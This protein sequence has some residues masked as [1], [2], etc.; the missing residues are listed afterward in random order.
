MSRQGLNALRTEPAA[1][2]EVLWLGEPRA[3]DPALTGGKAANLSRLAAGFD[4]PPGFVL[5]VPGTELDRAAR[6]TV[7]LAY[8]RLAA[9]T[10]VDEPP[11]A[12]RSSAVDEDGLDASFAG[13]HDTFLNV[14]GADQLWWAISRCV[15]SFG[16]DRALAYR[17]D[18]GLPAAPERVAVLVQWLVPA[19]A[20]GVV[21]SAHPV[22][23]ARDAVVVNA[24]FGL[25]ESVVAGTVTPDALVVGRDDLAV[26]EHA[27]ADKRRMTVAVPGGTR[28]VPVP[29]RLGRMPAIDAAQTR[30][31]AALAVALEREMGW[32]V[33]LE[34]AWAGSEL[35]L[36]QC[37]PITTL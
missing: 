37:R 36:L 24:S 32:P 6:A 17:R 28:E 7:A 15:A 27:I 26:R 19:A 33:D 1:A 29:G 16:A 14:S 21:F 3:A 10:G 30:A 25:G 22:T 9:L 4:V 11:V 35:F 31:A 12:V 34:V 8:R 20:A 23:G 5:A 2:P 13:Q 18:A